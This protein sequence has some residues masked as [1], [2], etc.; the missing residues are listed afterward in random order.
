MIKASG[1]V[2]RRGA[3][4]ARCFWFVLLLVAAEAGCR[5]RARPAE[6]VPSGDASA[7]PLQ[8]AANPVDAV[9][10]AMPAVKPRAVPITIAAAGDIAGRS[11]RHAE[12]A[13]LLHVIHGTTPLSAILALGDLQYPRGDLHDFLAYYDPHWGNPILRTLTRPVPGNHEYDQGRTTATGY[14][15]YFNGI[16]QATGSAGERHKGYYSFDIGA[17]HFIALN[18]SDGCRR[19]PCTPESAMHTWLLAD[20]AANRRRCVLAYYHH[21]RFQIGRH[22]SNPAIAPLWNVL[23]DAG[24]DVVLSGHDHNFQQ[25]A[26][27]NKAGRVDANGIRS[28]VVGTGGAYPYPTFAEARE[29][30]AVESRFAYRVGV[31]VM[32]LFEDAYEWRFVATGADPRGEVLAQGR[33]VCR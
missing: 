32:T 9:G 4:E 3:P 16:G 30:R 1:R 2:S 17:W 22:G 19:I 25:L 29:A 10:E 27:L 24:V 8:A 20:L 5:R 28:F 23:T 14:F 18:T 15:D 33:D 26:R 13:A 6:M 11:N 21:P 7:P 12:T 31:L